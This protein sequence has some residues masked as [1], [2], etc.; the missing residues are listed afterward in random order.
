[1]LKEFKLLAFTHHDAELGLLGKLHISPD[2]LPFSLPLL[3]QLLNVDELL[4]LSTCNRVELIMVCEAEIN[5]E[6]VSK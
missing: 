1:M 5:S 6:F 4:Y 3:R 2:S